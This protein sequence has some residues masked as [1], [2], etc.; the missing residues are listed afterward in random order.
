VRSENVPYVKEAAVDWITVTCKDPDR[1]DRFR[2]R[3]IAL[4]HTQNSLGEKITPWRF[5]GFEGLKTTGIAVGQ[6]PEMDCI[7]M[8]GPVAADYWRGVYQLATNCSRLDVQ[9]TVKV[10]QNVRQLIV[11]HYKQAVAHYSSWTNPPT[12][13]IRMSNRTGT[14]AYFNTRGS[15]QFGR[16]YDKGIESKLDHYASCIRYEVQYNGNTA[17]FAAGRLLS[18]SSDPSIAA[19]L[20]SGYFLERG[21]ILPCPFKDPT[22]LSRPRQRSNSARRL[23]WLESQVKPCIQELLALG[24]WSEVESAL[25]LKLKRGPTEDP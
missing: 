3:G 24:M 22:L 13:D 25:D 12:L 4:L 6:L 16:A 20:V 21:L 23:R 5:S 18:C 8:S 10:N 14:T 17:I 19:S 15:P 7:R 9:I 2:D 11:D 1:R